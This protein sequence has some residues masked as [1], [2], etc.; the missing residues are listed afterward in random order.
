M[1][2]IDLNPQWV[3]AGGE[4]ISRKNPVTGEYEP[5]PRREGVGVMFD[6]P[7]GCGNPCYV[8]FDN[9]LDGGPSLDPGHPRWQRKGDTFETLT[10]TPSILR[11]PGKG[12]CGWHGYVTNGEIITV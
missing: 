7:D 5:V 9:P 10:L 11:N 3:G 4:H 6:C 8:P 2:L 1:K 12:G